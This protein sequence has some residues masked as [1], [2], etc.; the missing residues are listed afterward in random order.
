[1]ADCTGGWTTSQRLDELATDPQTVANGYLADVDLGNGHALPL[2]T[3]P[4]QFD[5]RPGQ[6]SR[7]AE[8]GE[9]TEAVLL[10]AGL[11]WEE[12][13]TLKAAATIP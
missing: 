13:A 4:V 2:V 3:V 6:P 8:H 11:T 5:E 1:M 12:I 7:A 10:E 9:H